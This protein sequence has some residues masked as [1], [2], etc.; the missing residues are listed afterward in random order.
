MKKAFTLIELLVVIAI[1]AV[2]AAI[3]FPVFAQ[4][5]RAAKTTTTIANARQL[6]SAFALYGGE[7]DDLLPLSTEGWDGEG[8]EG[9]WVYYDEFGLDAAGRFDVAKGSLYPYVKNRDIYKAP[10]DPDAD[11]AKE[12]FA[13]NGCLVVPPFQYGINP[14]LSPTSLAEPAGTML[15]GE[16]ASDGANGKRGTN[17]GFFHP[18]FDHFAF[19]HAGG[20]ALL[21]V[22]GHA[23][24]TKANLQ[25]AVDGGDKPCWPNP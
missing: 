8:K 25:R 7:A 17:D 11:Q 5:K 10:L 18:Q 20:A 13:F 23:K 12:S 16:E 1:I 14:S 24:V 19:R 22:D 9:G 6:G 15:L 2:L 21:F 3:L 4:A